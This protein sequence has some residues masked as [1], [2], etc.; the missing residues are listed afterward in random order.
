MKDPIAL[1]GAP[2]SPYTRKMLAVL[3]YRRIPYRFL[4]PSGPALAGLP[5][6]K[7]SL[8]PTFY[9]P[10]ENGELAA[11]TDSSPIIRRLERE[12]EG[13]S[14]I[15]SDPALAF[16][17][18]LIEDYAD[19]WLTKAMFHYRWSYEADI[20][21]AAAMLPCWRG[22]CI[23]DEDLAERGRMVADRQIGRLRYVGSNAV[24]GPV[25]EASY[26]RFLIAF[27]DH[28][29]HWPY[30]LGARPAACDFA[31]FGQLTQLAEFDPTPTALTLQIAPRVS[32]WVGLMEDQS[33]VEPGEDD[34]ISVADPP[35]TLMALL[36]EIGR[37]YPPVMLA[38]A[39]AV[40]AGADEVQARVDGQAWTQQPFP[41]QAK[42]LRWLRAA[43]GG[44]GEAERAHV[45]RLLAGSGCEALFAAGA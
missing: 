35:P 29:R 37:V 28:L 12:H 40:M 41:Y 30:L 32:A 31:V 23:P 3:R 2:G 9:L 36:A 34:W 22:F 17:D 45:D 43:H 21:K 10:D 4:P 15:P 20:A 19:E 27:E 38:N 25:I 33:G 18:E 7:V 42:C 39:A 11:V 26:R 16:I 44:L 1:S 8:L 13:R 24:T 14:L 6:P 5:Q